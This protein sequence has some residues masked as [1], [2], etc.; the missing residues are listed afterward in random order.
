[1]NEADI[2]Y[3]I[4]IGLFMIWLYRLYLVYRK[5]R[6]KSVPDDDDY[7]DILS[8]DKYKVKGKFES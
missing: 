3:A 7:S 4:S 1:M 2:L 8:S 6:K 5:N